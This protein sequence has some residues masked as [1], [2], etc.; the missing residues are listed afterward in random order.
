MRK[1]AKALIEP[2][3]L[4]IEYLSLPTTAKA[5]IRSDR[6]GELFDDPGPEVVAKAGINWLSTAQD[7]SPNHDGGVARNYSLISGWANSYPETTGYIV[8]TFL[9]WYDRYGEA[10]IRDRAH[11]M[12]RWF[13]EIQFPE[14]GFQGGMIGSRPRVPVT[15]NTGQ[16]LLGLAAGV[17]SF[18]DEFLY[19]MRL[20]AD[21]LKDTQDSDGA[22][23]RHPTPFAI[24][25]EKTYETHV[26]WGLFEAARVDERRGYGEAG[27]KNVE[28][29]LRKQRENGWF[30][31]CCLD[32]PETPLTHT[33]GY[34][35]RGILECWRYSNDD[36]YFK[37]AAR[38][39]A[40]IEKLVKEDGRLQG[41]F[42]SN[43]K[44]AV[45]WV[46][47][48]GCAQLADC[49]LIASMAGGSGSF[50][51]TGRRL[52]SFVRRT[53]QVDG[54]DETRGAVKGSYPVDGAYGE[55]QYLNWATKFSIDSN[56]RELD[57]AGQPAR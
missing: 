51:D 2:V 46:C 57:M 5:E 52:N 36:K 26:A 11:R 12:L 31:D 18:G 20:A 7:N 24:G 40:I 10:G 41:R 17:E 43:W 34:A 45:S 22:W 9:N 21:W 38:T 16:I 23:R 39:L 50:Y 33:I 14:G 42:D 8:P 47:V 44:P 35:V 30:D 13:Q 25:G 19:T 29:A 15:F 32:Q 4:A 1:I 54:P 49:F 6:R 56:L 28:W 27:V 37:A 55:L 3:R 53:I 48:T